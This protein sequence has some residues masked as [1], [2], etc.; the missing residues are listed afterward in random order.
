MRPHH[1][2]A[3]ACCFV[4]AGLRSSTLRI[5]VMALL[6]VTQ[7]GTANTIWSA[8]KSKPNIIFIL[9]DDLGYGDVGCFGQKIIKTPS[10]DNMAAEG[11]KLTNFYAGATVCAPSRCVLMTGLHTGHCQVRGNSR[12][13]VQRLRDSDFTIAEALQKQGYNTALIGK[14][15]LGEPG[16]GEE[17]LPN[18][19]GFDYSFGYLNQRHAH[20]YYPEILWRDGSKVHLRNVVH[21]VADEPWGAAGWATKRVDYSHDLFMDDTL[22]YIDKQTEKPFFLY[23]AL[24]VPHA[25]NEGTRG[26]GNGQEVPDY[27]IYEKKNWPEPD[28]GQAAMITRMDAGIG[29]MFALLKEKKLDKNTIVFFTSDNGHHKEGGNNPEFF[30]ANGPLRGMKRALYEGGIRVPTIVRWPGQIEAGSVSDHIGYFGDFFATACDLSGQKTPAGLDSVSLL[31]VLTG[32]T[33][34][35]KQSDYLYWEF[36]EQGSRQ[37][38]RQGDWKAI[39][40]PMVTGKVELYN[41]K[42]D[43]GEEN[44]LAVANPK[45][46]AKLARLM[47]QAHVPH[48]DWKI[49]KP[50]KKKESRPTKRVSS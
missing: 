15:G 16:G 46:A 33:K 10:L 2:L 18:K 6:V 47:D 37:A 49:P 12:S 30:D 35:Q 22:Q 31:P 21:K 4:T 28:K 48:P 32:K 9:A 43:L 13:D 23:L 50:K 17:G 11:M 36:Y 42:D 19:Q 26:T 7:L 5:L 14:W 27:G 44:N 8:E 29:E 20:N 38:I 34:Q 45:M 25:N 40:Q 24:T 3:T 1:R 39:R 41:L